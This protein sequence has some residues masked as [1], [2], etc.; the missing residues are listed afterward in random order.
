M[1]KIQSDILSEAIDQIL[2]ES[3]K[4]GRKFVETVELQIGLKGYD[5]AKDKRFAGSIVLPHFCKR[6]LRACVIGDQIH[7]DQAQKENI[8]FISI[9]DVKNYKGNN[10]AK[11][12]KK[13]NQSYDVFFA[14][15]TVIVKL[16]RLM[17]PSLQ[18]AGKFPT[19]IT[20]NDNITNKVNEAKMTV[21]FQLKKVVDLACPIGDVSMKSEDLQTNITFAINFLVSLLKKHWQNVKSINIKTTM[22]SPQRIY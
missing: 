17:G 11:K 2:E 8:P 13:L 10:N 7:C 3:K 5:P 9:D 22:G 20:S 15:D 14:S 21:K 19:P 1:S 16:P 4:K 18:R 6:K 12:A